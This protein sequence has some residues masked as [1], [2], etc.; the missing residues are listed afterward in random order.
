MKKKKKEG[1]NH[2]GDR[3]TNWDDLKEPVKENG[4]QERIEN[5]ST[6]TLP[7]WARIPR[8]IQEN[9]LTHIKLTDVKTCKK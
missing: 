2:K 6:R 3:D 7:S 4:T 1:M 8:R 9:Y 5:V